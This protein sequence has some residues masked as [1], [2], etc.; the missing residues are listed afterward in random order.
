M[1]EGRVHECL[2]LVWSVP[3]LLHLHET[4]IS[5]GAQPF[6]G[7]ILQLHLRLYLHLLEAD[8]FSLQ[9]LFRP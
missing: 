8:L 3:W 5:D 6:Q 7:C 1:E 9:I 2:V 4:R